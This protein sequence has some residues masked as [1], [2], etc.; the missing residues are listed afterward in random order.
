VHVIFHRPLE[1]LSDCHVVDQRGDKCPYFLRPSG[2]ILMLRT[3]TNIIWE[4][5]EVRSFSGAQRLLRFE[6]EETDDS[7]VP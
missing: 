5:D 7:T 6:I 4:S 1:S 2:D 3:Q